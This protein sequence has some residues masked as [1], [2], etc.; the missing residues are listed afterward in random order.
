MVSAVSVA[1]AYMHALDSF[2]VEML[3]LLRRFTGDE[4]NARRLKLHS[5]EF[6]VA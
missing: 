1:A 3:L 5:S 6:A 4:S 2:R